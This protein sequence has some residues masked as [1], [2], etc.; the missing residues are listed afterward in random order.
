[1]ARNIEPLQ[2]H[3][4]I[5]IGR[6]ISEESYKREKKEVVMEN[7]VIDVLRRDDESIII[8]EV[9]KSSKFEKSARMQLAFYLYRLKEKGII[10][11]GE[12]MFPKE[13]KRVE[14]ILTPDIE[15]ELK[16]TGVEIERIRDSEIPP[17]AEKIP[18]CK[19]C[20]YQEFCWA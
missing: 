16:Q 6:L 18:F 14:V 13:K 15:E 1:M 19:N 20:G 8:G 3:T 10:A 11:K 17:P 12:L 7:I 9:K 5:E 2:D 4:F